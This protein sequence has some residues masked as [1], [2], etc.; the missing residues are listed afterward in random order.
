MLHKMRPKP[1]K[2]RKIKF[3]GN[4]GSQTQLIINVL[5]KAIIKIILKKN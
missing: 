5:M 1:T 2:V 3:K 4:R